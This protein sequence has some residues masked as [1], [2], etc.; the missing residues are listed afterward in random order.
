MSSITRSADGFYHPSTE[1]ELIG[2][3]QEARQKGLQLRV[4]GAAHSVSYAVY[5][6]PAPGAP[7]VVSQQTPPPGNAINVML[8][9]YRK[10][11]SFDKTTG[12]ITAQAGIHLGADPKDPMGTATLATSL[13]YQLQQ[14]GWCF[15]DLG[16]ITHQTIGG[17]LS[18]GS[19]GGSTRYGIEKNV[20]GLRIIDGTGTPFEVRA[21]DADPSL[22]NAALVS[23][24]ALGVLST[25]T[26]RPQPTFNIKGQ[27]AITTIDGA[28]I[29]LFGPGQLGRPSLQQFLNDA[30]YSRLFWWPQRGAERVVVWQAG[31]VPATPDFEP[32]EY[33]EFGGVPLVEE[34]LIAVFYTI[35]GNL[36][37]LSK[38]KAKL[39]PAFDDAR[40]IAAQQA[41]GWSPLSEDGV[42]KFGQAFRAF[43]A[44]HPV[45]GGAVET[46]IEGLA[47]ASLDVLQLLVDGLIDVLAPFSG[48]IEKALPDIMRALIPVFVQLDS[49]KSGGEKN[50]PQYF[51]D[52]SYRGLPMDNQADDILVGTG[53]TEIWVPLGRTQEVMCLFR[54]YFAEAANDAEAL[55]RTGIYTWELYAAKTNPGWMSMSYTDGT[56]EWKDGAF[57][58]DVFWYATFA[59]NPVTD[60]YQQFWDLLKNKGV[61]FRLHWGKYQPANDP[62][63][64]ASWFRKQ[65]AHW[66][67]FLALRAQKDPGNVFL[68]SYWKERFGL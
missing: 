32:K 16:G 60:F 26:F 13:L 57:R 11:L 46:V 59:G 7:D 30:D 54:D 41:E 1:A 28:A 45:I 23:M 20:L 27:E 40:L 37:D 8:D 62:A 52:Y 5:T 14:A 19:S 51:Q 25:V 55:K 22:F 18:T 63:G 42:T 29:D 36:G 12:I 33:E 67:D 35:V 49:Q 3:V 64:W 24:G 31:Q 47:D 34:L 68:T 50:Q 43:V 65:Y 2:L 38:A 53:F 4:R 61:P 6:D 66:D 56:D 10:V 48:H 21:D 9:Q 44:G 17:F 58:V 15:E 39:V